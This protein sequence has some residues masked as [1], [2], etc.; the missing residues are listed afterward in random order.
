MKGKQ[1]KLWLFEKAW[2]VFIEKNEILVMKN[3]SPL[4]FAKYLRYSEAQKN[5]GIANIEKR[6][7]Q[8]GSLF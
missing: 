8:V 4:N 2:N 7:Q 3:I 6:F 1:E 5:R